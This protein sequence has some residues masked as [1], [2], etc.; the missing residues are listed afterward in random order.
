ASRVRETGHG[1]IAALDVIDT[2][3]RVD[4]SRIAAAADRSALAAAQTPQGFRRDVLDAAYE[5]ASEEFT[6]DAALVAD[7]GHDVLRVAGAALG[8]T[9]TAPDDLVRARGILADARRESDDRPSVWR[10][11]ENPQILG[12]SSDSQAGGVAALPR[13][14]VGTDVHAYGGD[15]SLWL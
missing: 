12:G 9:I 3:K 4:G 14:G 8:F 15:G 1:V 10:G 7:A 5:R 6:D 11:P 2:I 13:V